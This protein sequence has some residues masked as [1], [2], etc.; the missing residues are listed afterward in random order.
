MPPLSPLLHKEVNYYPQEIRDWDSKRLRGL[1]LHYQY[2]SA[3]TPRLNIIH[4]LRPSIGL[5]L[6]ETTTKL[7]LNNQE[8]HKF[9]QMTTHPKQDTETSCCERSLTDDKWWGQSYT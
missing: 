1:N 3:E 7:H 9:C 4:L 8:D 2:P 6:E 5:S